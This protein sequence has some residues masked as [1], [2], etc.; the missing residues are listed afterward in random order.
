MVQQLRTISLGNT[1]PRVAAVG[2]RPLPLPVA[3]SSNCLVQF[4]A[5][6][7]LSKVCCNVVLFSVWSVAIDVRL[8]ASPASVANKHPFVDIPYTSDIDGGG[9]QHNLIWMCVNVHVLMCEC[10]CARVRVCSCVNCNTI[11]EGTH[12]KQT[13][14]L[15]PATFI[16]KRSALYTSLA[17]Q[18]LELSRNIEDHNTLS[19]C[20]TA[21]P[22]QVDRAE[23]RGV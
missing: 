16:C 19:Y 8:V 4:G 6:Q 14:N 22:F 15:L 10:A 5:D 20:R 13:N 9:G 17:S 7:I 18:P 23:R 21:V 3:C 11:T 2:S 12:L 1:P